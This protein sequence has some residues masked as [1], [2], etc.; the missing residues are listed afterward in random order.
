VSDQGGVAPGWYPDPNDAGTQRYWDGEAWTE[1]T[2]PISGSG[3]AGMT[4]GAG[5]ASGAPS[6]PAGSGDTTLPKVDTWLWQSIVV[7]ILCCLPL[8][9]VGIVF[10]SQAQSA[11]NVGNV[12]EARDKAGTARLMTLIGGGIGLAASIAWFLWFLFV[13]VMAGS[14]GF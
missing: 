1:H 3:G 2:A 7:T 9:V 14:G 13:V 6:F 5:S 10:A 12:V 11:L 4:S 8:G